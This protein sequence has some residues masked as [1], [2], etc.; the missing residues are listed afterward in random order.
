M[1]NVPSLAAASGSGQQSVVEFLVDLDE[2]DLDQLGP[3]GVSPLCA[4][5]TW[6]Y[7]PIVRLLVDATCDVNLRNMDQLGSTALHVA[8]CQEHEEVVE[9]LLR[10][11]ADTMLEDAEGRTPCDFASVSDGVWPLFEA[12]GL[13]RTPKQ[14]LLRKRLI[15]RLGAE[16]EKEASDQEGGTVAAY[17][18]PGS[19]YVRQSSRRLL[20]RRTFG[21]GKECVQ[22]TA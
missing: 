8:A 13:S 21:N 19:A 6:G 5:A 10:A 15:R 4:A 11:G 14:E 20:A 3:D 7:A 17:T 1:I 9:L 22:R 2:T 12:R 18:R 16:E